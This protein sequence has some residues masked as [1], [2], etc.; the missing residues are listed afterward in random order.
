M[1]I[2]YMSDLHMEFQE[3]SRYLKNNELPVTGD[4]LVLA[5]DIFYLRDKVAPL[6][7]FWKWASENYR[8]VLIVPGNHAYYNYSDVME[9]GQQWRWIFWENVGYYQNQVVRIDD[10]DFVLS[11]LWSRISPND[12]Y[13]E[14]LGESRQW[15]IVV[16][17]DML[18]R[19]VE[20][21]HRFEQL[22]VMGD[23]EYRG[24]YI[25]VPRPA[26]EEWGYTEELITSGEYDSQEA[27]L[28]DWLAFNPMETLWFHVASSR[29]GDFRS[30]RVTDRK[31][32]RFIITNCPK[33]TDAGL[34]DTWCREN[35]TRLFDYLERMIDVIVA[36]PDGFNDYVAH[37]LPYQQRKGR[38]A[39]KEFN[40]I[41]PNFKIEVEDWETAIKALKDSVHGHYAPLLE[42]MTIRKYCTYF[43]IAN[44]VYE[45]YHWKRG[46]RG[47]TYTDPQDVPDEL[48]D[49][50]YYKRKKFVD[51]TEMYDIDSPEDFMRFA[52]DHYG[53]L[54]LSRLNIFASNDRQQGW[55]IFVSN[56]YSTNAGLAI[57]VATAL[58]KAGEPLLKYDL[59][60]LLRILLEEDY[61]GWFPIHITT[62]SVIRKKALSMNCPGNTSAR[63]ILIR[64]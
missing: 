62:I 34:D 59:E 26:P 32:T 37:N 18:E 11:T 12:E 36:N 52:T 29:Y 55:K 21:Q 22:A 47:R 17:G 51:V 50:V 9:R 20:I 45:A 1:K 13:L 6:T 33:C 48:R 30:I 64:C 54:G 15:E 49:V 23:D 60:K 10:T 4:V 8:Q 25:E 43:R 42:T 16:G 38:I 2:Q 58:Y 3:N 19:L 63:T 39:Q 56:S 46:F 28:V 27:F 31:H 5:G 35:L 57:E 24:F 41:V 53:E 40:R 44:E 61:A 7:K 14:A